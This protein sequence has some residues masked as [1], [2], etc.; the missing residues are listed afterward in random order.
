M[1]DSHH[2]EK[3]PISPLELCEG[4]I[5]MFACS[6]FGIFLGTG[7]GKNQEPSAT[8]VG[9][10]VGVLFVGMG[11]LFGFQGITKSG[12]IAPAIATRLLVII[13]GITLAV[14]SGTTVISSL[15]EYYSDLSAQESHAIWYVA[16]ASAT[17]GAL[18]VELLI[19]H[20]KVQGKWGK[21][22]PQ[23]EIKRVTFSQRFKLS[24][25]KMSLVA[26]L[27]GLP[28]IVK[29][30]FVGLLFGMIFG[31]S[32]VFTVRGIFNWLPAG[33]KMFQEAGNGN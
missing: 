21:P 15:Q 24:I 16:I 22:S 13:G 19:L 25:L 10:G 33:A 14:F 8:L 2:K 6:A 7:I 17:T 30:S 1:K 31:V 18:A 28:L 26:L 5:V 23:Q 4:I 27:G 12:L 20:Q 9:L 29:A 32:A 3:R 11:I